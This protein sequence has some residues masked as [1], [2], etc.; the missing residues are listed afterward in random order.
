MLT[1]ARAEKADASD[2]EIR[3]AR[4]IIIREMEAMKYN[5]KVVFERAYWE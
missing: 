3:Q 5:N 1:I 2:A 4:E